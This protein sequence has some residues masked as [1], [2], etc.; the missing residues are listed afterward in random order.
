MFSDMVMPGSLNGLALAR[1]VRARR[2]DLPILLTTGFS[3]A[4]S[5]A[6][7]ANFRL[8]LKPYRIGDLDTALREGLTAVAAS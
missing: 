5:E 8:L 1:E 7:E 2:P 4:A 3:E 6:S